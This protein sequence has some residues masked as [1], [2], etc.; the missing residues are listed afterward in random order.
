MNSVMATLMAIPAQRNR[1]V[2]QALDDMV[3]I[4]RWRSSADTAGQAFN[5]REVLP[6]FRRKLVINGI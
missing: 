2:L 3:G 4:G 1:E 6:F 5:L